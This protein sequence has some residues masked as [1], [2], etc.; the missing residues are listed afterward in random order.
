MLMN[1]LATSMTVAFRSF[2][3][4]EPVA[5]TVLSD[6]SYVHVRWVFM[7]VPVAVVLLTG[8]FLVATSLWTTVSKTKV[9][10]SSALCSFMVCILKL[11]NYL[12]K[13]EAWSKKREAQDM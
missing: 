2:S 10:K 11:G 12:M 1:D 7:T 5:G 8:L 3:G 13:M 6:E 4:A 9:W